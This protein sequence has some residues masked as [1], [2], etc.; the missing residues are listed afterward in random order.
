MWPYLEKHKVTKIRIFALEFVAVLG[1]QKATNEYKM[2]CG[3]SG[4][5]KKK[6]SFCV[7]SLTRYY[8]LKKVR[9]LVNFFS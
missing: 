8:C 9:L 3:T 2:D 1:N 4:K 6:D 7:L 5:E